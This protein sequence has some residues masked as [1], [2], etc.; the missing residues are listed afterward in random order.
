M[1]QIR[2]GAWRD[3]FFLLLSVVVVAPAQLSIVIASAA[4]QSE[5]G[6]FAVL[7]PSG[8]PAADL[9]AIQAALAK[10][11][12]W[13]AMQPKGADGLSAKVE[14]VLAPGTYDLCPDG[15]TP[16]A[17]GAGKFC[18]RLNGWENL[19]FR[20]THGETTI[21]LLN[22]TRDTRRRIGHATS[23]SQTLLSICR[24]LH[25]RRARSRRFTPTAERWLQ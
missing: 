4:A 22:R 21:M 6:V 13:Q 18:L 24:P 9:A 17:W 11:K 25:S 20:G 5:P 23:R 14:V 8:D 19:A 15:G 7:P 1:R 2:N 3:A 10:A 16:A 12:A